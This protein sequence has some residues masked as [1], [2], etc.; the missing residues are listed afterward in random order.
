MQRYAIPLTLLFMRVDMTADGLHPNSAGYQL[1]AETT[2]AA[3]AGQ[4]AVKR[5]ETN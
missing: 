5:F 2:L 4:L 3:L 1:M